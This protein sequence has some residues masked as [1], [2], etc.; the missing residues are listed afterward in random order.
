[1]PDRGPDAQGAAPSPESQGFARWVSS[2]VKDERVAFLLIGG[3]NTIAGGLWFV[4]FDSAIGHLGNG[5]GHYLALVLTY[6]AAIL[7]AF[8]SYRRAVFRVRGLLL[9]DLMRF[10]SVY[11]LAFVL[12]LIIFAVLHS[13]LGMA[14]LLAQFVNICVTA[15]LSFLLHKNYSFERSLASRDSPR[16]GA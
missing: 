10:S 5:A 7:T 12:N 16:S 3:A 9:R 1:M 14:P 4:L 15:L 11:L 6:V 8:I 13:G 2:F